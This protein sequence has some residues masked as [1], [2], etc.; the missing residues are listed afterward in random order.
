[1]HMWNP[2]I[3]CLPLLQHEQL[4]QTENRP[5]LT[6]YELSCSQWLSHINTTQHNTTQHNTTQHNTTQHNTT[7]HNTTQH[8]T[9]QHN[10][11]RK[12]SS[13]IQ[14]ANKHDSPRQYLLRN[15]A[16]SIL[17]GSAIFPTE[18]GAPS[19]R[20]RKALMSMADSSSLGRMMPTF[21]RWARACVCKR[22]VD[23]FQ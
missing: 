10:T 7:Q 23:A 17:S 15:R 14:R 3:C 5:E 19:G 11:K 20:D 6:V 18:G 2:F 13:R 22:K 16:T 9:T 4:T 8:N 1:M 21:S 12:Q